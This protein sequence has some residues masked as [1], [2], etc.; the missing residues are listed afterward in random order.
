MAVDA[1][2][3]AMLVHP[4]AIPIGKATARLGAVASTTIAM[5]NPADAMITSWVR[6]LRR[7]AVNSA[8]ISEPT[9]VTEKK[10]VNVP[11]PPRNV[12]VTN[13]DI[14]TW[15]LK[16]RVPTTAIIAS[17]IQRSGTVRTYRSPARTCA[18][19]RTATGGTRNS[20]VFIVTNATITAM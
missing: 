17:G 8:P 3:K 11:T 15:K 6:M 13:S 19:A 9:A 18:F 4:T 16:A 12:L 5:P 14:T 1:V 10:M 7:R 2:M 20:D